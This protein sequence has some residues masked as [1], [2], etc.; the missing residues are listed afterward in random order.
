MS[1]ISVMH[2]QLGFV[3]YD[4]VWGIMKLVCKRILNFQEAG[5]KGVW[6]KSKTFALTLMMKGEVR[7][8]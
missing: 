7:I 6:G 5:K 8:F 4:H 3:V 1:F 2:Q